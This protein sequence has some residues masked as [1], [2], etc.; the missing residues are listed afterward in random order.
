MKTLKSLLS[1]FNF[2]DVMSR[3]VVIYPDEKDNTLDYAKVYK[4]LLKLDP[5]STSMK[6]HIASIDKNFIPKNQESYVSGYLVNEESP[7]GLWAI[8]FTDWREWLGMEI[9]DGTQ[10]NYSDLDI[11]CHSLWEMTVYS[12]DYD[13]IQ[14]KLEEMKDI[15]EELKSQGD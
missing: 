5:I 7:E 3:M 12:Y 8:E 15:V 11:V 4:Q 14:N 10:A 9:E 2:M 1:M 13:E 6:I